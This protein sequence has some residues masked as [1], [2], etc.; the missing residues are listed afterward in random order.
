M[1]AGD[2][3]TA[4]RRERAASAEGGVGAQRGVWY[5]GGLRFECTQCGNCCS[6]P[7]G[8]VWVTLARVRK[9][10]EFLGLS[11]KEFAGRYVRRVGLRL[12]LKELPD[13][14]CVF[15]ERAGGK[16][17]CR[18]YPVRPVQCRTWPFWSSNLRTPRDWE[19]TAEVCPGCNQGRLYK[20]DQ[21]EVI[22]R[23]RE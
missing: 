19:R 12:S 18:V 6:G 9:M 5:A 22:R 8:Y 7:P 13:G 21:I 11:E 4:G 3:G 15:L 17:L 23:C 14:D 10:A 2:E 20:V 16:T 1:S